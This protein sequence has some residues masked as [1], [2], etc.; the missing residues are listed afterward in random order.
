VEYSAPGMIDAPMMPGYDLPVASEVEKLRPSIAALRSRLQ[1]ALKAAAAPRVRMANSFFQIAP[2]APPRA[3]GSFVQDASAA[4][5]VQDTTIVTAPAGPGVST[6]CAM[7]MQNLQNSFNGFSQSIP[8]M[9]TPYRSM[10][11]LLAA[12]HL[13]SDLAGRYQSVTN[14][15]KTLKNAPDAQTASTALSQFSSQLDQMAQSTAQMAA[16][17][18]K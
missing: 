6:C 8:R 2:Q 18:F 14:S 17:P 15:F 9:V 3:A 13:F 7:E 1:G 11:L 12:F 10:N 16:T 5:F 4:A